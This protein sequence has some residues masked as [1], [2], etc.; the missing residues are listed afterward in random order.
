MEIEMPGRSLIDKIAKTTTLVETIGRRKYEN[1]T[2]SAKSQIWEGKVY[3]WK[4]TTWYPA[5]FLFHNRNQMPTARQGKFR[6]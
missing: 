2:R 4:S 5:S 3:F 1:Q 6:K